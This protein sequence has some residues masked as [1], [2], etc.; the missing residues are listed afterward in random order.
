MCPEGTRDRVGPRYPL[1]SVKDDLIWTVPRM[2]PRPHVTEE[3]QPYLQIVTRATCIYSSK[4][5]QENLCKG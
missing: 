3:I 5:Q 4:E 2:T 1:L